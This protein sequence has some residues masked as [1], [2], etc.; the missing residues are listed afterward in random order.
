MARQKRPTVR[1]TKEAKARRTAR[2]ALLPKPTPG[3]PIAPEAKRLAKEFAAVWPTNQKMCPEIPDELNLKLSTL[4]KEQIRGGS[5]AQIK[6]WVKSLLFKAHDKGR[7]GYTAS[8][9]RN[10]KKN[11]GEESSSACREAPQRNLARKVL[12]SYQGSAR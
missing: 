8:F 9:T 10:N 11:R 1:T 5:A 3:K 7:D 12:A 2:L 6:A 4:A